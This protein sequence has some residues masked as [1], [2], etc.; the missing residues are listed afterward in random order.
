LQEAAKSVRSP[1]RDPPDAKFAERGFG[2]NGRLEALVAEAVDRELDRLVGG[3]V[4]ADVERR[5]E[6]ARDDASAPSIARSS[7]APATTESSSSARRTCARCGETKSVEGFPKE[8]RMCKACKNRGRYAA[9][10]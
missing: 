5:V 6:T 4:E 8:R 10:T 3:H 7:T 2:A 9:H 1:R